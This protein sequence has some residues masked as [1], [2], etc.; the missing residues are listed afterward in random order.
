MPHH[1]HTQKRLSTKKRLDKRIRVQATAAGRRRRK[2][3][4]RG[5]KRCQQ[6]RPTSAS[7]KRKSSSDLS[8]FRERKRPKFS[9][10]KHGLAATI[11]LNQQNSGKW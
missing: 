6:G 1:I 4:T 9:K 3:L 7:T 8:V 10:R 11:E 5:I 2:E